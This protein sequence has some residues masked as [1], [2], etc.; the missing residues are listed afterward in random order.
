MNQAIKDKEG[1]IGEI[2][3]IVSAAYPIIYLYSSE[4]TRTMDILKEVA[5]KDGADLIFTFDIA[6]GFECIWSSGKAES[7]R[8][9][10]EKQF[11]LKK[12]LTLDDTVTYVNLNITEKSYIVFLDMHIQFQNNPAYVRK[13]KNMIK[14]L[15]DKPVNIFLLSPV[16]NIPVEIE[17]ETI[18]LEIPLPRQHEVRNILERFLE[19]YGLNPSEILKAKFVEALNGLSEY[20]INHLLNYCN[21]DG[22]INDDDINIINSQ[23][24]Q[25]IKKG[26]I[27]E[28]VPIK[29][30]KDD[31][32]G[33]EN[34]KKW[35]DRKKKVMDKLDK[36]RNA[37][38]DTPKGILLFG[39]PGCG[40]SLAAKATAALFEMPLLRLDMGLILGSYLGQSEENIRKATRQAESISPCVLW[41]DEI[42]KALAGVGPGGGGSETS[43]RVFGTILTWM[44]EK[45]APV[46][47]F[48]TAN[49][50]TGLPP[51]FMRKGRFDEIFY[52]D[53]PE[54]KEVVDIFKT[55][56]NK[57]LMKIVKSPQAI[58][59]KMDLESISKGIKEYSGADIEA[60]VKDVM[61]EAFISGIDPNDPKQ[62]ESCI[63]EKLRGFK[64]ISKTM[65]D[66]IK[67]LRELKEKYDCPKAN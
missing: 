55:H 45:T 29:E 35:L 49:D 14:E 12:R 67:N 22:V 44:Q 61:E 19:T 39:M 21:S 30:T 66:K 17:K 20:E 18:T 47:V 10:H 38:V 4:E 31:I 15:S 54:G 60:V 7:Y 64:P 56:L 53:F 27:L 63:I 32:G 42:E 2:V 8:K 48:A 9:K 28:F 1:I 3:K 25:L 34:L 51:E 57:R 46:F 50:I 5:V 33:L 11:S 52:V 62:M 13:F 24:Q 6:D 43:V 37:G 41:I 65:G 40:K 16:L 36:A 23:K 59:E 26:G 58:I